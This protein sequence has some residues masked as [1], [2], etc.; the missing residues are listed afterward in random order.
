MQCRKSLKS[1]YPC[2]LKEIGGVGKDHCRQGV[3]YQD[4][5]DD[6]EGFGLVEKS[7]NQEHSD[8]G[9]KS[10]RQSD[11]SQLRLRRANGNREERYGENQEA[12]AYGEEACRRNEIPNVLSH[13]LSDLADR[14]ETRGDR[15][16]LTL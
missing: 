14:L 7:S 10:I 1:S 6:S 2:Q 9:W 16:F 15:E 12:I 5:L 13:R 4:D 3:G 11:E 8:Q